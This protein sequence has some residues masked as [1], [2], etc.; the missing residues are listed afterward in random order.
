MRR[1]TSNPQRA[2]APMLAERH[3]DQA[4]GLRRMFGCERLRVI[5][6]V[7]GCA[8]VGRTTVAVNLGVALAMA[9]RETLLIDVVEDRGRDTVLERLRFNP[10]RRSAEN[11]A[12]IVTGPHGLRVLAVDGAAAQ[13][14]LNAG[15]IGRS[16]AYA[17]VT[18]SSTRCTGWL[19]VD[20]RS[21]EFVVVLGRAPA[22]ITRA[23]A[24]I[25]RMTAA[26]LCRRFHVLINRVASDTEAALIFRNMSQVA[27]GYLDVDLRLL[28]FVPADPML[29]HAA[30]E[31]SSLL[32]AAPAAPAATAFLRL[33]DRIAAWPR[34][35]SERD[36][37][38]QDFAR[39]VGAA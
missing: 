31:R 24:L 36:D 27:R 21:R 11:T 1:Q 39:A 33:A 2:G 25:K 3:N 29:E 14:D 26:G 20:E 34:H 17:L 23:Y 22:T 32:D 5:H 18:D 4:A 19:P 35:A 30:V 28:G 15:Q 9:G 8:G 37:A 7:A 12:S 38:P 16:L 13:V 6:I 10:Q